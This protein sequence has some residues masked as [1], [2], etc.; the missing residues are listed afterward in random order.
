MIL[1]DKCR[2]MHVGDWLIEPTW[3]QSALM[4]IRFACETGSFE[5]RV[6]AEEDDMYAVTP[7]GTAV[8]MVNGP[9]MKGWSKF[10]GTNT[11]FLRKAV[12]AAAD[13]GDVERAVMVID[14]PGGTVA[15]TADLA[16]EV[17]RFASKKPITA[18]IED[19]GA[20]AAYWV[21]SQTNRITANRTA[22]VGSIGVVAVIEDTSKAA[23]L[24]G[25]KVHVIA[26]GPRK[27]PFV[28]G[29]P[30]TEEALAE[31]KQKVM[32][33]HRHF[34]ADVQQGRRLTP[35]HA[36]RISDGRVMIASDAMSHGLID[37]IGDIGQHFA[38]V[39]GMVTQAKKMRAVDRAGYMLAI[40]DLKRKRI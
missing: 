25:V 36:E 5:A 30:I 12:R 33:I 13:A 23:D 20:S 28:D 29:I 15:G 32:E 2:A 8:F 10:G 9:M 18:H 19:L 24:S 26:S 6:R 27:A 35:T 16:D 14:S 3:L 37:G 31:A 34:V 40:G 1:N 4:G 39:E 38:E 11:V 17:K 22:Q 7:R 21:A